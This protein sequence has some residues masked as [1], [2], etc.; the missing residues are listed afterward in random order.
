M[1]F[2]SADLRLPKTY[3]ALWCPPSLLL[4]IVLHFNDKQVLVRKLDG[5]YLRAAGTFPGQ[6]EL[7]KLHD[8]A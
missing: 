4:K 6:V 3:C 7:C 8:M 5:T 1:R 2:F